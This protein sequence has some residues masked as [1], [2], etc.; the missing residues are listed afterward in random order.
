MTSLSTE[1]EFINLTPAGIS[2]KWINGMLVEFGATQKEPLLL[3][4]DS[5]NALTT[6]LNPLNSARTRSIDIRYKWILDQVQRK[7][8]DLRHLAGTE[9]AADGLTK[10]L[11]RDKHAKFVKLL[12]LG[13][14]TTRNG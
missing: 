13:L 10:P 12:G 5:A 1:A 8:V 11:G 14:S 9:M 3:F 7:K 2:L 6:A 4:T